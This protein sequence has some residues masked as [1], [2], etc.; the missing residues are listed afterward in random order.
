MPLSPCLY[1]VFP[2]NCFL[3]LPVR[4]LSLSHFALGLL[5]IETI[6]VNI[7]QNMALQVTVEFL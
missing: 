4:L 2:T 5:P 7:T 3:L 1:A 6:Q